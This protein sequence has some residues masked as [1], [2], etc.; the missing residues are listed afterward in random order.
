MLIPLP[1]LD[2]R[3]ELLHIKRRVGTGDQYM[4]CSSCCCSLPGDCRM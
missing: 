2:E 1:E 4:H 3:L